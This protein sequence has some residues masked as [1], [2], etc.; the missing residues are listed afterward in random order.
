MGTEMPWFPDFV[1]AVELV[2]RPTRAAARVD[3]VTQYFTTLNTSALETVWPGEVVVY[4]PRSGEIH[5]HRQLRRFVNQNKAWLGERRA[6]NTSI[7]RSGM[8]MRSP[9]HPQR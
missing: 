2:R 3:P 5:G 7:P 8:P 6:R 1:S 9:P 4:D